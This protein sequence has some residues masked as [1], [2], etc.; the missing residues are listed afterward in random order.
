MNTTFKRESRVDVSQVLDTIP[1]SS[2]QVTYATGQLVGNIH[3]V[4]VNTPITITA[5]IPLPDGIFMTMFE[6]MVNASEVIKDV[7]RPATITNG[8]MTLE[9]KF[10]ESGNPVLSSERLNKGL[11]IIGAPFRLSD[12]RIE[13]DIYDEV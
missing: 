5:N 8:V 11:G 12:F 7:R 4:P 3:W 13:F 9:V 2:I 1:V 6:I 10:K